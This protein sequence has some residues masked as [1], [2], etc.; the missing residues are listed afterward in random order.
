MISKIPTQKP[1]L[2]PKMVSVHH[3]TTSNRN[4]EKIRR[5]LRGAESIKLSNVIIK[6]KFQKFPMWTIF[7]SGLK[8]PSKTVLI[9]P[10]T[11]LI[12]ELVT[13]LLLDEKRLRRDNEK[14]CSFSFSNILFFSTGRKNTLGTTSP[15]YIRQ[16]A[17]KSLEQQSQN[18]GFLQK[19]IL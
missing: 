9:Y 13:D 16:Q 14:R 4:G 10:R 17:I 18:F 5:V 3:F 19:F 7:L 2:G 11:L 1:D 15:R 6:K 8:E 12:W